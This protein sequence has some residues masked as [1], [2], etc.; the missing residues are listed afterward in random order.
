MGIVDS[1]QTL[2]FLPN[3]NKSEDKTCWPITKLLILE[4]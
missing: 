2:N 3:R 1:N 4:R